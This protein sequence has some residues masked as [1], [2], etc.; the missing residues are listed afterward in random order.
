LVEIGRAW[1]SLPACWEINTI[2]N[3]SNP[4]H[5]VGIA[6]F[7]THN[8][9]VVGSNLAESNE[10]VAFEMI[11]GQKGYN[12]GV[13]SGVGWSWESVRSGARLCASAVDDRLSN[14]GVIRNDAF[15]CCLLPSTLLG[16]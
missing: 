11:L 10:G 13:G 6:F 16:F 7:R 2:A 9:L 1:V 15:R 8:P 4:S 5:I 3:L 14:Q 12:F